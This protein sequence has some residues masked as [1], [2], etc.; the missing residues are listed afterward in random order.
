MRHMNATGRF[1]VRLLSGYPFSLSHACALVS[2]AARLSACMVRCC[3]LSLPFLLSQLAT[4]GWL[5]P[6]SS[7]NCDRFISRRLRSRATD[8]AVGVKFFFFGTVTDWAA[9]LVLALAPGLLRVTVFLTALA[10]G[11]LPAV[12]AP[13]RLFFFQPHWHLYA[14]SPCRSWLPFG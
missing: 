9:V 2:S 7:A 12:R 3:R 10:G 4:A 8:V 6:R 1:G 5:T 14:R 13:T 11:F